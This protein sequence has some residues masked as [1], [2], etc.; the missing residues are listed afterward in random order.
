M[1]Y[2]ARHAVGQPLTGIVLTTYGHCAHD[3]CHLDR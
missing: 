2:P 1:L 3:W